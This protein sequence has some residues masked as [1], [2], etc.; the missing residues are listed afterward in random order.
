MELLEIRQFVGQ[1]VPFSHLNAVQLSRVVQSITIQYFRRGSVIVDAGVDNIWLSQVRTGAVELTLGGTDLAARLGEGECFG[2]PSLIRNGPTQNRVTALEDCL[3]YRIPKAV[4]V[5]LRAAN[6]AFAAFFIANES[7]R[8]R[9]AVDRLKDTAS[10]PPLMSIV[11]SVKDILRRGDVVRAAVTDTVATAAAIMA[12]RDVST[13]LIYESEALVGILTDKDLRRRVLGVGRDGTSPVSDVMTPD[14]RVISAQTPIMAALLMMLE[15]HIH[16]LP[17]VENDRV[18]G[19]IGASDLLA[20][21]GSSTLQI[22]NRIQGAPTLGQVAQATGLLPQAVSGL[23]DAGVDAD[24][25]GRFVSSIGEQAHARILA[26]A[27]AELGPPPVPFALV[28]FGSLARGEQALGSDQDN[29]FIYADSYDA[30]LHDGYF[31]A[32]ATR[33]CDGLNVAGYV[34]CPGDIMATNPKQRLTLAGWRQNFSRW[35]TTPE[36]EAVL[37]C[38]IFFDMRAMAGDAT[39][40]ASLR[41]DAFAMAKGNRI[42]QSF[43]ARSAAGARIPLGF[44]R[45]LLLEHDA[46]EGDVLNLKTQAIAPIVDIARV[47]A[48]AG[49]ITVANTLERLTQAAK[50]GSLSKDGAADLRDCL[51]FIRDVR[52]RH[53]GQ[54]IK[55]GQ[56]PSNNLAPDSLSR[57]DREHLR[58]AFKIIRAQLDHLRTTMAGGLT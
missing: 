21:M 44:F 53:Q 22:A 4:F 41:N 46:E 32:L 45:N 17:V 51:A 24:H 50:L 7:E 15:M 47:H 57:F 35:I 10:D 48:L 14:P 6:A 56:H 34:Y 8:L 52:F 13:L 9:H 37:N 18:I 39:L 16:H 30:T 28:A 36:P 20:R 5:D 54:Q 19:V 23:V 58:D 40:V 2:Y 25:I 42:F 33:L 26:L 1:H 3:L 11:A 49:G 38:T 29:G 55:A 31:A 27:E 12:D 43:V